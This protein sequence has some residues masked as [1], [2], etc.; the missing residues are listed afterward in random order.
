MIMMQQ[1]LILFGNHCLEFGDF[2]DSDLR[3]LYFQALTNIL[4]RNELDLGCLSLAEPNKVA[5][6]IYDQKLEVAVAYQIF[7]YKVLVQCIK[8]LN[9][10][11]VDSYKQ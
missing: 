7:I 2:V 10:R 8:D 4:N 5:K 11:D 3:P 6:K 1:L 9:L